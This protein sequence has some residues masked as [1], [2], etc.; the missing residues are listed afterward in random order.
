MRGLAGTA[1]L[2]LLFATGAAAAEREAPSRTWALGMRL[3]QGWDSNVHF[4]SAP[5]DMLVGRVAA[6]AAHARRGPRG[7]LTLSGEGAAALHGGDS[8]LN[9]ATYTAEAAG[10]REVSPRLTGHLSGGLGSVYA[11]D[12]AVLSSQALL[13]PLVLTRTVA[14]GGG[15]RYRASPRTL[16]SAGTRY[17]RVRFAETTSAPALVGGAVLG[18]TAAL[19]RQVNARDTFTFGFDHRQSDA[20]GRGGH[21]R[22]LTLGWSRTV[23]ER[24]TVNGAGGPMHFT[25][26]GRG[27]TG[28][29]MRASA[30][31]SARLRRSSLDLRYVRS[32]DQA[33]GFGRDHLSDLVSASYG[34]AAGR[35]VRLA[36][37]GTYGSLRDPT[38]AGF[39][40]R[41]VRCD[42]EAGM[43]VARGLDVS[44]TYTLRRA[45]PGQG[46]A[47]SGQSAGLG[48]TFGREWRR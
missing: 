17:E 6:R 26:A 25:L 27:T 28:W 43:A 24:L 1:V 48:M 34:V 14:A 23:S 31:L 46:P 42:L 16:L 38:D 8:R 18:A 13:L 22:S 15:L 37:S 3:Q 47:V 20:A 2:S 7:D 45:S 40:Q 35:K 39:R 11:R 32:V 5:T 10:S 12:S 21:G 44:A 19:D 33:F 41:T 9:Q 30:G 4:V 29:T 36:A